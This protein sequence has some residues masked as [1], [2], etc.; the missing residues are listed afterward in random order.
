M[1]LHTLHPTLDVELQVFAHMAPGCFSARRQ[2]DEQVQVP[3]QDHRWQ[4]LYLHTFR[5]LLE[6]LLC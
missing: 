3:G 2:A 1:P 4:A 5:K 6:L